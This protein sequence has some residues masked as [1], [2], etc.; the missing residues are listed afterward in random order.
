MKRLP[1]L[2]PS[3]SS[4][5]TNL[6]EERDKEVV[7]EKEDQDN[8]DKDKEVKEVHQGEVENSLV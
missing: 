5:L 1:T 8:G 7:D 6:G 2:G 4:H 3:V